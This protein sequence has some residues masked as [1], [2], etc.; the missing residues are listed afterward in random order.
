MAILPIKPFEK[1]PQFNFMA[2]RPFW[3]W[4]SIVMVL[5]VIGLLWVQGLNYGIDFV[6]GKL[7]EVKL[8]RPLEVHQVREAVEKLGFEGGTFQEFG[9]PS[10]FLIRL[11]GNDP[12]VA[13]ATT[14]ANIAESLKT[15]AGGAETRRVEFVGPQVGQEL[16]GKGLQAVVLS[17]LAILVYLWFRFELRF[18]VGAI[19]SLS[20]DVI[21]TIGVMVLLRTEIT[22]TVLAAI[23]TLIGYSL[24]ETIVIFDRVR[25]NRSKYPKMPLKELINMSVNQTLGRTIMTGGSVLIVLWAL[26][27]YGGEAIHDFSRVMII[28]VALGTYSSIFVSSSTL[29]AL[30]EWYRKKQA[31]A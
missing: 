8:D 26:F 21:L 27:L 3:I 12:K 24:N 15:L 29:L 16:R 9:G 31:A 14:E 25:E 13:A 20:H 11:P 10:E 30:E 7:I 19:L 2:W 4:S 18:G 17:I 22:L 28:G 23:L 6:G 5:M 1:L